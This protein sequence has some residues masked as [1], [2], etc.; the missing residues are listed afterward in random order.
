MKRD[1]LDFPVISR[2]F[3]DL[4][5]TLLLFY[6]SC[7]FHRVSAVFIGVSDRYSLFYHF[8]HHFLQFSTLP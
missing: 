4:S 5:A 8:F 7:R 2:Q 3:L 6:R 1:I